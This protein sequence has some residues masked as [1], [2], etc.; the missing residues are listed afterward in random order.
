[1]RTFLEMECDK[2]TYFRDLSMVT[3][4]ELLYSMERKTYKEGETIF[5]ADQTIDRMIII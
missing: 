5:A 3:K 2:I 1:M 4:Q